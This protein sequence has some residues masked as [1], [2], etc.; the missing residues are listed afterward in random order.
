MRNI[1]TSFAL[2]LIAIATMVTFAF[3]EAK[4]T[5]FSNNGV[6]VQDFVYDFAVQGGAVGFIDLK[7]NVPNG[8]VI[9]RVTYKVDTAF[10]SGGSATVALGDS[11]TNARYLAAT[12]YNN[13]AF[14]A[15]TVAAAAIG[16]P[17]NVNAAAK[18][19]VGITVATAAL[20]A[21]KMHLFVEYMV[22]K[23]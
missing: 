14:T 12:A 11:N 22:P 20:T 7:S 3:E 15:G 13:A 23:Q 6:M 16:V 4:A 9:L 1:F 2:L 5:T 18:G 8:A 17:L 21:G 19:E 10:T